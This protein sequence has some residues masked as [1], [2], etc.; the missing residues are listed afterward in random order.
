MKPVRRSPAE[1]FEPVF[2]HYPMVVAFAARRGSR[3]PEG[4]AAEALAIAWRRLEDIDPDCCR[5]WLLATARNLLMDEFRSRVQVPVDPSTIDPMNA[6]VPDHQLE[7]LDAEIDSALNALEPLDREA[8]ILIAWEELSPREAAQTL[9]IRPAAFR[10]RLHRARK[11]FRDLL[12]DREHKSGLLP[13][14]TEENS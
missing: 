9:G 2:R 1:R 13:L 12:D 7:S 5:P 3:D 11:R 10:V 6:S 8:L 14:T 4:I